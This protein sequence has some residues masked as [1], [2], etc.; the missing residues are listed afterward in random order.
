METI[1]VDNNATTRVAPEV[2][3]VMV[4]YLTEEYFNPSSMYERARGVATALAES[5]ATVARMLGGVDPDEVLF[6]SGATE[7]TRT[8]SS[9]WSLRVVSTS[10]FSV[11][12][13]A[14]Q[15]EQA[16]PRRQ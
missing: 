12:P 15:D 11:F 8:R 16:P 10:I 9:T 2:F 6:T 4:P 1:Y 7:S 3:E 13:A 14:A 5:R